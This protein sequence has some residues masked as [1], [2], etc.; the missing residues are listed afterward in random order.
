MSDD[1]DQKSDADRL[2]GLKAELS[3]HFGKF[4]R[5]RAT[6]PGAERHQR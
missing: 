1:L 3:R 6:L 2:R 4:T 5:W